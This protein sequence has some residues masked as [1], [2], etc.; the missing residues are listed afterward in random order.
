MSPITSSKFVLSYDQLYLMNYNINKFVCLYS[1][2][3]ILAMICPKIS[4]IFILD[5]L[6]VDKSK[7]KEFIK[8]IQR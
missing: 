6:D 7:Y 3:W 4:W 2:H 5:S 8:C 1:R